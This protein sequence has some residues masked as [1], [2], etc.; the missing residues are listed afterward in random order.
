MESLGRMIK[1]ISSNIFSR[2]YLW[3]KKLLTM[4]SMV[5]VEIILGRRI[6][7][8]ILTTYFPTILMNVINQSTMYLDY[9]EFFEAILTTNITC[10]TVLASLYIL[11]SSVVPQTSYV[12]LVDIWFLFNLVYPFALIL[13]QIF[14]QKSR[15]DEEQTVKVKVFIKPIDDELDQSKMPKSGT[16]LRSKYL[17]SEIGLMLGKTVLPFLGISFIFL[18]FFLGIMCFD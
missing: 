13:I 12:K 2:I 17:K 1:T 4:E 5:Q 16:N 3:M 10:M 8:I 14:I 6:S 7:G 18:Y 11:F 9:E 15:Y